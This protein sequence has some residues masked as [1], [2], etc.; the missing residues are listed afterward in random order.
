MPYK[1]E[2]QKRFMQAV[3]NSPDFSD[4]VGVPQSVGKK[5]EAHK[6]RGG[7]LR[8]QEG[9]IY[10]R[11]RRLQRGGALRMQEGGLTGYTLDPDT[12]QYS[13]TGPANPYSNVSA[14]Q[15]R[16]FE[17]RGLSNEERVRL[18]LSQYDWSD[19]YNLPELNTADFT[20]YFGGGRGDPSELIQS[21]YDERRSAVLAAQNAIVGG[22]PGAVVPG[23][24]PAV[25]TQI[26]ITDPGSL[27]GGGG[28]VPTTGG[29]GVPA[30]GGAPPS[31]YGAR[32]P[33]V[34]AR[35][36]AMRQRT[37]V[38]PVVPQAGQR[39]EEMER[40]HAQLPPPRG[41]QRG[42][43]A[44]RIMGNSSPVNQRPSPNMLGQAQQRQQ[45]ALSSDFL[46][47]SPLQGASQMLRQ[48][49]QMNRLPQTVNRQPGMMNKGVDRGLNL[50]GF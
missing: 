2:E 3:A 47:R 35:I 7:L 1:S 19:P 33:G 23:D 32:D 44:N 30:T 22:A 6:Q 28:G 8:M 5:F 41:M 11:I 49:P 46:N 27:I 37:G 50:R 40:F 4:K 48:P 21:G 36:Q 43:A 34:E 14:E 20:Q 26:P 13:Y 16:A 39:R 18:G 42:G 17:Q 31:P 9:G 24:A 12:G 29:A 10:D 25:S 45:G 15:Q 38:Q